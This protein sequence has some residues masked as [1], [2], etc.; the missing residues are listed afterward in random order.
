M[1]SNE[2]YQIEIKNL[3]TELALFKKNSNT[4]TAFKLS[5]ESSDLRL[6]NKKLKEKLTEV[7]LNHEKI[8]LQ[9]KVNYEIKIT[10]L[11]EKIGKLEEKVDNMKSDEVL[12]QKLEYWKEKANKET[13]RIENLEKQI[14]A[15]GDA[16]FMSKI[17]N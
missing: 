11:Q 15:H 12:L 7:E 10:E 14:I 16:N 9:Q 6:E 13:A 2:K 17:F 4:N 1:Y 5:K 3:K 8:V